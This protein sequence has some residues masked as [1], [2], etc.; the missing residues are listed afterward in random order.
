LDS[1]RLLPKSASRSVSNE[2]EQNEKS[3]PEPKEERTNS[4]KSKLSKK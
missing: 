4:I 2:N 3:S 1:I